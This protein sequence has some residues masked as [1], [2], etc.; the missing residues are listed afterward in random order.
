M[1]WARIMVPLTGRAAD[2]AMLAAGQVLAEPF[3]A[4]LAGV[5]APAD[6]ADIVPWMSDGMV[7][8]VEVAAIEAVKSSAAEGEALSR[9]HF[10]ACSAARKSFTVL[11]SPVLPKLDQE[12]RLSDVVV[13]DQASA[14]GK[15]RLSQAFQDLLA[16]EQRP[17]VVAK[18]DLPTPKT[19]LVAWN[20]GKEASRAARTALPLLQ[21]AQRVVVLTAEEPRTRDVDPSRLAQFLTARGVA[22]EARR[23][24]K[25]EATPR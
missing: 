23:C 7:G 2:Q 5:F 11:S 19:V 1:D 16:A 9:A 20:G 12:A 14:C 4:E 6:I 24:E 15:T 17:I 3:G 25:G 8:G 18:G 13:F 21:K 10:D 22:A